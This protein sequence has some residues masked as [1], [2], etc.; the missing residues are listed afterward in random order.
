M[1]DLTRRGIEDTMMLPCKPSTGMLFRLNGNHLIEKTR[2]TTDPQSGTRRPVNKGNGER[3]N[4]SE[5]ARERHPQTRD[6]VLL[7]AETSRELPGV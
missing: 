6:D 1:I 4:P 5:M 7:L 2:L 3:H